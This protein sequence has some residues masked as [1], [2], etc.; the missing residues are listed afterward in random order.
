[1]QISRDKLS[2]AAQGFLIRAFFQ[3]LP[4]KVQLPCGSVNEVAEQLEKLLP[5]MS[6]TVNSVALIVKIIKKQGR[7]V[8]L[9]DLERTQVLLNTK[10]AQILWL[11]V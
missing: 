1:M 3:F 9:P 5:S 4:L 6:D 10:K 8:I 2:V 7:A 11:C